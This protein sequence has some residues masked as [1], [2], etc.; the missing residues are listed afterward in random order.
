MSKPKLFERRGR[1][2]AA[3]IKLIESMP[4]KK[5]TDYEV[6][7]ACHDKEWDCWI[8]IH[9]IA[10]DVTV[11]LDFHPGGKEEILKLAG[12]DATAAFL[13]IHPWVNYELILGKLK[14]GRVTSTIIKS[15]SSE[16]PAASTSL[17][18]PQGGFL[19]KL[20]RWLGL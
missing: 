17:T 11:Y 16:F 1:S 9:G 12:K 13:S 6:D 4:E 5:T 19:E 15:S 8:G 20:T 10:Y 14:V 7:L 3:F 2:Q 18:T